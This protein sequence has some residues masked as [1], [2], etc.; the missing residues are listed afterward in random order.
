MG[1]ERAVHGHPTRARH[2][3]YAPGRRAHVSPSVPE[4]WARRSEPARRLGGQCGNG[5]APLTLTARQHVLEMLAID[6]GDGILDVG[7]KIHLRE[8]IRA[9]R[10]DSVGMQTSCS[11][12]RRRDDRPTAST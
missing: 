6:D 10:P 8:D 9:P 2:R 12:A 4:C 7:P 3:V 11:A 5:Y 1:F